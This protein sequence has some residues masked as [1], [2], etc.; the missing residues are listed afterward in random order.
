MVFVKN[1]QKTTLQE[2]TQ[3]VTLRMKKF[4]QPINIICSLILL[5]TTVS[6]QENTSYHSYQP[7]H[8]TGWDSN[9]TLSFILP[10]PISNHPT[11][12]YQIGIRHKDSYKFRDIW[13]TINGDTIHIYLAD[14]IGNWRGNGIGEMRLLTYPFKLNHPE[15]DSLNELRVT[16]IMEAN[17]LKGIQDI[18]IQI[19]QHP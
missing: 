7:V 2:I 1:E 19:Q 16:H 4:Q 17:P 9:D 8:A 14:S 18:G 15:K 10:Q 11:N 6:C 13:L 5:L 12:E 3:R